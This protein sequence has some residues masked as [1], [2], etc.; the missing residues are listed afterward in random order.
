MCKT[1][2]KAKDKSQEVKAEVS[3]QNSAGKP[4]KD[5]SVLAMFPDTTWKLAKT[6][7]S[8]KAAFNFYAAKKMRVFCAAPEHK[9]VIERDWLPPKSLSIKMKSLEN[10]GS[11]VFTESGGKS[12][13]GLCGTIDPILDNI[14]RTYLYTRTIAIDGGK[15]Q[16]VHFKYGQ[17]LHLTD[18]EGGDVTLRIME[19]IGKSALLEYECN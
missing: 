9:G 19:I 15:Q 12:L 2:R 8:G 14:D 16:P 4:L 1:K 13:P 10:G 18:A 6:D 3:V 7:E 11:Q 5:A 17:N